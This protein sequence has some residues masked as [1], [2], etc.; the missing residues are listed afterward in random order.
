MK[1][2]KKVIIPFMLVFCLLISSFPVCAASSSIDSL[3]SDPSGVWYA[4][5]GGTWIATENLENDLLLYPYKI[6]YITYDQLARMQADKLSSSDLSSMANII[7]D[8]GLT[9]LITWLTKKLGATVA[10]KYIPYIGNAVIAYDLF[11]AA[12]SLIT[13]TRFAQAIAAGHGIAVQYGSTFSGSYYQA[14][15][16]WSSIYVYNPKGI[17]GTFT[18]NN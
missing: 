12:S 6:V 9:A 18:A 5:N 15:D 2:L 17:R 7:R 1:N 8:Q 10:S 4:P 11:S 16:D 13:D 3:P 14:Y